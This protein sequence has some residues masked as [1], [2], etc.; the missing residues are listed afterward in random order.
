[1]NNG[2][3]CFEDVSRF[4][5]SNL[6]VESRATLRLVN[7]RVEDAINAN[8]RGFR[9]EAPSGGDNYDYEALLINLPRLVSKLPLL[10]SIVI[11]GLGV[12]EDGMTA[13]LHVTSL[14]EFSINSCSLKGE[15]ISHIK[16]GDW[17][18]LQNL[19]CNNNDF[20]DDPVGAASHSTKRACY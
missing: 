15:A 20:E 12:N 9:F 16:P 7:M 2:D 8:V 19:S 4:L 10:E 17:P 14:R 11:S 5:Y 1:M 3:V 18:Q 13:L 6:S